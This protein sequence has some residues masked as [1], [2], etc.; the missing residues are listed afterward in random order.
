MLAAILVCG[1]LYALVQWRR[2]ADFRPLFTDL[3][4]E[5]AGGI[6]QKLKE[7]GVEYRWAKAG[8]VSGALGAHRRAA[9]GHGRG[10]PSEDRA[11]RL[12]AVR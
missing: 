3:A 2:E 8:S 12:R 4:P 10:G 5:D 6:V 9:N 7:S 1:G 11:N